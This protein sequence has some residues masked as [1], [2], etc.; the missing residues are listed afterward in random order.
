ME[1]LQ[2][3]REIFLRLIRKNPVIDGVLLKN[4][5]MQQQRLHNDG[6]ID[7]SLQT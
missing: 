7:L 6:Q 2:V 3:R 4:E 1:A 5:I